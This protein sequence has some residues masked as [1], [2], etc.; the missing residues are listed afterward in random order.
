[1]DTTPEQLH[2]AITHT[3]VAVN[4]VQQ[5]WADWAPII[6]TLGTLLFVQ[7]PAWSKRLQQIPGIGFVWNRLAGNYGQA[8]N[9][10]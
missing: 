8:A 1:M 2:T 7:V 6:T 3:T 5:A 10:D 4:A 9:K